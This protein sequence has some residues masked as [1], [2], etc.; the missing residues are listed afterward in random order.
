MNNLTQAAL[1]VSI[2]ASFAGGVFLLVRDSTSGRHFEIV[3]PTVTIV[4]DVSLKVYITGAVKVPGVYEAAPGAI[5][6]DVVALA[7]GATDDADLTLVN[8]ARR[9]RDE[10]HWHIPRVGEPL[11]QTASSGAPDIIDLNS[12]SADVLETLPGIGEVKAGAIVAYREANGPF[13]KVDDIMDVQGIGP[14][15]LEGIRDLVLVR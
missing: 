10:D 12:A 7:A 13:G 9:V 2:L 15:I 5:L 11:R 3:M 1:V 4:P 6:E 8:L 14:T